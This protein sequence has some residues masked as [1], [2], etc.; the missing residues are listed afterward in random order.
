MALII[1][2]HSESYA[3]NHP[4]FFGGSNFNSWKK[5]MTVFLQFYDIE[6]WKVIVLGPEIP[7][8]E[9]GSIKKY[10]NF[11]EEDWKRL[12]TNS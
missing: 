5:K 11:G 7:K 6:T 12:H 2:M 10:K 1:E 8:N 4:P 9:Y 3:V